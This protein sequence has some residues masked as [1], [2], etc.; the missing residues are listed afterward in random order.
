MLGEPAL[1]S[2]SGLDLEAVDEIDHV[3]EA[4]TSTG[5]D[6]ASGDCDGQ[7]GLAGTGTADQHD[8]ALLGDEAAG[9]EIVDE[10]LV[11]RRPVELEVGDVLGKR[12]LG[13]GELVLDR[14]GLLLVDLGVEQVSDDALG[15][16]LS[17]DGSRHDLVEGSLHAIYLSSPMRSNN[18]VRSIRWFS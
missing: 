16:V 8:V 7:M 15:F 2:I 6:A 11:D 9:G 12:Q 18:W 1:P 10:R 5:S 13:D 4:A 14:S 17:L 3:V